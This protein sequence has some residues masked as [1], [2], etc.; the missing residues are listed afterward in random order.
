MR[1]IKNEFIKNFHP[2]KILV[3]LTLMIIISFAIIESTFKPSQEPSLLGISSYEHTRLDKQ[4]KTYEE[5]PTLDNLYLI[6]FRKLNIEIEDIQNNYS[7]YRDSWQNS[8]IKALKEKNVQIAALQMIKDG[9]DA[10]L[11]K[12]GM[13]YQFLTE[14]QIA[15]ELDKLLIERDKNIELLKN[16][17]YDM[18]SA[19]QIEELKNQIKEY[20]EKDSLNRSKYYYLVSIPLNQKLIRIKEYI[21]DNKITDEQ[22]ARVVAQKELESFISNSI[23]PTLTEKDFEKNY[24]FKKEYKTYDNY[25]RFVRDREKRIEDEYNRL[26]Y[27]MEKGIELQNPTKNVINW[28]WQLTFLVSFLAIICYAGVIAREYRS[29]SIRL[30]LTQGVKRYKILLSK[31][32]MVVMSSY[33]FYLLFLIIYVIL[34]AQKGG[35]GDLLTQELIIFNG[36]PMLVNYFLYLLFKIIVYGLPIVFLITL[37]FMIST[38]RQGAVLATTIS[39]FLALTSLFPEIMFLLLTELK[40]Y[41][42]RFVPITYLNFSFFDTSYFTD[43]NISAGYFININLGIVVLLIS[44]II[45]YIITHL[46]F[47]KR[48]V[49]N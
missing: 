14:T 23:Y 1:L 34:A 47:V 22:D 13:M 39:I 35:F 17:T 44:I 9:N 2:I 6:Y 42:L 3:F 37:T 7:F 8:L 36:N 26:W 30:L 5:N 27:A 31:Y 29:G 46:T 11:F 15:D 43:F 33:V 25:L 4:T 24:Q 16:G 18:F 38:I 12:N 45:M 20:G 48:D 10:S 41:F 21:V 32:L 28:F 19:Y 49:R 40:W